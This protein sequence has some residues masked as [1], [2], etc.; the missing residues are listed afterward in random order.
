MIERKISI[1]KILGDR[2]DIKYLVFKE[3]S[4]EVNFPLCSL[5]NLLISPPQYG[6]NEAG[7]ERK[8]ITSPRYIRITDINEQG[9]LSDELGATA[10]NI[11]SKYILRPLQNFHL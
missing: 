2:Y 8:D 11:Q 1:S 9:L 3:L 10:M 5:G 6:A 7:I 4:S